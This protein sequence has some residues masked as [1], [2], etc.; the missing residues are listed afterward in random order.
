MSAPRSDE[1]DEVDVVGRGRFERALGV[2]L[3]ATV[4]TAWFSY[5]CF[6]IDEYFQVIELTRSKLA[7]LP[8]AI[9]ADELTWEAASRMR[10][11]L[12]PFLYWLI[13][14]SLAALGMEQLFSFAFA[15]R[16]ATGLANVAALRVFVRTSLPWQG[17][18]RLHLRVLTLAGFLPYLF[19]R[20][21]SETSSMAAL[22]GATAILFAGATLRGGGSLPT[23][24][25]PW[26]VALAGFLFG[27][28]F[29][30]R[31]QT[32]LVTLGVVAWLVVVAKARRALLAL[33]VGGLLAV[34][35]GAVVDRWGYGEWSLPAWTYL[36]ANLLE[37]AAGFF[38]TDPPFA[39]LWMSPANLFFPVVVAFLAVVVLG[40]LRRPLH[41]LTWATA[42]FVLVHC[43]LAH[44][45]E[46]FLFPV[47]VLALGLVAP[48]ISGE[49]SWSPRLDRIAAR[50]ARARIAGRFVL[51]W[52]TA[53][54]IVLALSTFG[55]NHNARFSHFIL[56]NLGEELH[57]TA[58]PEVDINRP[59]FHPRVWDVDKAPEAEIARRVAAGTARRYLVTERGSLAGT[60]L[61]DRYRLLYTE[62][63]SWMSQS[64]IER[65]N[66]VA[67]SPMRRLRYRAL[68]E[69]KSAAATR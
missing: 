15:F 52:S 3:I 69:L 40:W 48:A 22:T 35:L 27:A 23:L 20:T 4:V 11:W 32:A 67:R 57:A 60:G 39:Y 66:A 16:L 61:E 41:P 24:E 21:S 33:A 28:A 54:M 38:G 58:L 56:A 1:V 26:R 62:Q 42:P 50:L 34:A 68:Y 59:V 55:W 37:G 64:V 53:V 46:R 7:P 47:T 2:T 13:A 49:A 12:Q 30:L 36:R 51:G 43:L 29:E 63:P 31:F 5:G 6:H 8:T 10:P 25:T 17:S 19:V 14:K 65:Y 18:V 45:E 44:K 9:T